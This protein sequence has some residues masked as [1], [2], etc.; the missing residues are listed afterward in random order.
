MLAP[1]STLSD[2]VLTGTSEGP[3]N[4]DLQFKLPVPKDVNKA[5]R[6]Q[7]RSVVHRGNEWT[8]VLITPVRWENEGLNHPRL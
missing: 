3:Q 6:S 2:E 5:C 8:P 7:R 1:S 4:N